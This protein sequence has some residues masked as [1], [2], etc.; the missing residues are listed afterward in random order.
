MPAFDS[1][2]VRRVKP[3]FHL[4][5]AVLDVVPLPGDFD[6]LQVGH[7]FDAVT[8]LLHPVELTVQVVLFPRYSEQPRIDGEG[9]IIENPDLLALLAP[10]APAS[11]PVA[12]EKV[13][14]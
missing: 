4:A 13:S 6:N 12:I 11:M 7:V 5:E 3:A 9:F 2:S 1:T 8:E 14:S 10:V